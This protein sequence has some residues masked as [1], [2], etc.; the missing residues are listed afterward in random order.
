MRCRSSSTPASRAWVSSWA[1]SPAFSSVAA[2]RRSSSSRRCLSSSMS[3]I[4]MKLKNPLRRRLEDDDE[5]PA[6]DRGHGG[7]GEPARGGVDDHRGGEHPEEGEDR[8]E[9]DEGHHQPGDREGHEGPGAGR[10]HRGQG[11]QPGEVDDHRAGPGPPPPGSQGVH[12][13]HPGGGQGDQGQVTSR[14][15]RPWSGCSRLSHRREGQ[16]GVR[17]TWTVRSSFRSQLPARS[18]RARS[19]IAVPLTPSGTVWLRQG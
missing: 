12:G 14:S 3:L 18:G 16:Q 5:D 2:S 15:P 13:Q 10:E 17:H 9:Q 11:Q 6:G 7:L 8:R 1:C 4:P 19:A